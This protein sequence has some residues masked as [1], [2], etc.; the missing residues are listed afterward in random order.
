M[1]KKLSLLV[2]LILAMGIFVGYVMGSIRA[3]AEHVK[4]EYYLELRPNSVVIASISLLL[5][6]VR[7]KEVSNHKGE[8][9]IGSLFLF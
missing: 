8:S 4:T 5:W 9:H 1:D 2:T 6:N 7:L 3:K